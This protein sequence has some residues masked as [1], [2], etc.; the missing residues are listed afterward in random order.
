MLSGDV[1]AR[2]KAGAIDRDLAQRLWNAIPTVSEAILDCGE[3][4]LDVFVPLNRFGGIASAALPVES[5]VAKRIQGLLERGPATSGELEQKAIFEQFSGVLYRVSERYPLLLLLDDLQWADSGSI[6]L[7][8]HLGRRLVKGNILILGAYRPAE[9]ALGRRGERH[10]LEASLAEFKRQYGDVWIDFAHGDEEEGMELVEEYLDSEPNRLSEEFRDALYAHTRGHALFTVELMRDLQERGD[11]IQDDENYWIESDELDW[12]ALPARVEGV[13]EARINRLEADLREIL[14]VAS[15]EGEEFTAQVIASVQEISERQLVGHLSGELSKVHRLVRENGIKE[16]L[17]Q[18]FYQYRFLH[19][20]FQKYLYNDIGEIERQILHQAVGE[21]LEGLYGEE[22]DIISPQLA[23]HFEEANVAEKAIN[24]LTQAGDNA[25]L[26]FGHQ[27][28]VD[29]YS[30]AVHLMERDGQNEQAAKT[31]MKLGLTYQISYDSRRSSD[32]Y[33]RAFRLWQKVP[34]KRSKAMPIAPQTLRYADVGLPWT[35]DP[36]MCGDSRSHLVIEQLFSGLLNQGANLEIIPEIAQSWEISQDG[37]KY[38]F[39]LQNNF[40]W[41]DGRLV[42]AYDFEYAWKR[43]L[44]PVT[45]SPVAH[46]LY[47]IKGARDFHQGVSSDAELVGVKALDDQSL[48]VELVTPASYFLQLMTVSAF[49]PVPSH[50]VSIYRDTWIEPEHIVT[51]G[52][53]R[54][55]SCDL[56]TEITMCRNPTYSGRFCGNIR[57][58]QFTFGGVVSN[59]LQMYAAD[60]IDCLQLRDLSFEEWELVLNYYPDECVLIPPCLVFFVGFNHK[61]PPFDDERVRKAFAKA[62]NWEV[63]KRGYLLREGFQA[64]GGIV[65]PGIP[66]Y[67]PGIG[68]KYDPEQARLLL[69]EAGYKDGHGFPVIKVMKSRRKLAESIMEQWRDVLGIEIIWDTWEGAKEELSYFSGPIPEPP[70]VFI[71]NWIADYPDPDSFLR[72]AMADHSHLL[73]WRNEEFDSIIERAR[74]TNDQAERVQLY[75]KADALLIKDA[76]L[77]PISYGQKH[78]LIKP[79]ITQYQISYDLYQFKDVVIEPH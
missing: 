22:I 69:A 58:M 71:N 9:V 31:W 74:Q 25:R 37:K 6:N 67:S 15:V 45:C 63:I 2:W 20:L 50:I 14:K 48:L 1:E 8:F 36:C 33:D 78:L 27:E 11:L 70:H 44:S 77:V 4:L 26:A 49:F 53:F 21:A 38:L 7:L 46:L 17:E 41:S 16:I 65:P 30:R 42:T 66:G 12:N 47:D 24:Y 68:L 5:A 40:S 79:W 34:L 54:L 61:L 56:K 52:P 76:H 32:A 3:D 59:Y 10:P 35:L 43:V 57:Q 19:H 51:N 75:Q 55:N 62:I 29:Y 23:W 39:R 73:N 64:L 18:R 60:Q 72:G 13:I 28:A